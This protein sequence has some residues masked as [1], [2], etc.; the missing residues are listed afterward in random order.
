MHGDAGLLRGAVHGAQSIA[1]A[2]AEHRHVAPGAALVAGRHE[3]ADHRMGLHGGVPGGYQHRFRG[4]GAVLVGDGDMQ[5]LCQQAQPRGP[6]R[7]TLRIAGEQR[8]RAG[9]GPGRAKEGRQHALDWDRQPVGVE[10]DE[11]RMEPPMAVDGLDGA[12]GHGGLGEQPGTVHQIIGAHM[13]LVARQD[14]G[15][16][17]PPLGDRIRGGGRGKGAHLLGPGQVELHV[18]H[19]VGQVAYVL[20]VGLAAQA[21]HQGALLATRDD[22]WTAA[23][24]L[25]HCSGP[26]VG[27]G[28]VDPV[29]MRDEAQLGGVETA[30]VGHDQ[31]R[32]RARRVRVPR[33]GRCP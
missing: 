14:L 26:A 8:I 2:R 11:H 10:G 6:V 25:Q 31:Q 1:A 5:A 21:R 3:D 29:G 27:G 16:L 13:G 4:R 15:D 18:P 17:P 22:P 28:D 19:G 23:A 12:D 33:A 24:A 30:S 20:R 32:R 9:R 7:R